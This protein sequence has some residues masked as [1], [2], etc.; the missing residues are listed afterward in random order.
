[1]FDSEF[2]LNT[3]VLKKFTGKR[4]IAVLNIGEK[5]PDIFSTWFVSMHISPPLLHISPPLLQ[6][7]SSLPLITYYYSYCDADIWCG[8]KCPQMSKT[9]ILR[10][11]LC[12]IKASSNWYE[13]GLY[14]NL[15]YDKIYYELHPDTESLWW[16]MLARQSSNHKHRYLSNNNNV[17]F[18]DLWGRFNKMWHAVRWNNV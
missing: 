1:M 5:M 10:S 18:I 4:Y 15:Q 2:K 16:S 7:A 17:L 9:W 12:K 13:V 3:Q 6:R 8:S 14:S 11:Q